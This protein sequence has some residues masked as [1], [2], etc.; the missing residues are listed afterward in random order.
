MAIFDGKNLIIPVEEAA[1]IGLE[2]I[3]M[4]NGIE[5]Q[6]ASQMQEG[7][8]NGAPQDPNQQPPMPPGGQMQPQ[9]Q[10]APQNQPPG[11]QQVPPEMMNQVMAHGGRVGGKKPMYPGK[12]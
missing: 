10:G 6:D 9:Q 3:L 8:E 12:C 4:Q 2:D 1:A 5:I 11:E 7:Q